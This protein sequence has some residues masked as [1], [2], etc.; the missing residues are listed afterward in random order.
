MISITHSLAISDNEIDEQ[1]IRAS[2][3]G[4]QN[5][6]KVSTAVQLRFDV[7]R[8]P[9]LPEVVRARLMV[10]AGRRI[11]QDGIL[12]IE[13]QRFRS[14]GRNRDDARL[15]L[16]ALIRQATEIPKQRR[17]TKPTRASELRRRNNKL[18]HADTKKL[19]RRVTGE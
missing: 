2:G 12:T 6:N 3:P 8:S 1:F 7:L 18:R 19:R 16:V 5:V 13:A 4:G 9:A 15:R 14:Q 10:L 11:N 17:I